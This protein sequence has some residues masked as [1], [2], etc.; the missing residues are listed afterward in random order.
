MKLQRFSC[1]S[2]W[3]PVAIKSADTPFCVV[4][5]HLG[6]PFEGTLIANSYVKRTMVALGGKLKRTT[7]RTTKTN[8]ARYAYYIRQLKLPDALSAERSIIVQNEIKYN[9]AK[10]VCSQLTLRPLHILASYRLHPNFVFFNRTQR[11]FY[12]STNTERD[13]FSD[14]YSMFTAIAKHK[15]A[16]CELCEQNKIRKN[17]CNVWLCIQVKL[18]N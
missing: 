16:R 18:T 1:I 5:P 10:H 12:R 7:L 3:F 14:R 15:R 2:C 13:L 8:Y 11:P 9:H 17:S 6:G 4:G